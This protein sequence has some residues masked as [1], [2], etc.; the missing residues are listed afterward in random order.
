MTDQPLTDIDEYLDALPVQPLSPPRPNA[1][2][3]YQVSRWPLLKPYNGFSG[4]ER[5]R[6]GQLAVWL[7]AAG[8]VA[9]PAQCDVCARRE[10]LQLHNETYYHVGRTPALCR[11]CHRAIHLRHWHWDAW[12]RIVDEAATSGE[13]WFALTPRY[14]LNLAE[15]LRS[16]WGWAVVD[17][18]AS[19]ITPLSKSVAALL[20]NNMLVHPFVP[21]GKPSDPASGL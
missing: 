11:R 5:R 3:R 18:E 6:G 4:E 12:R 7:L 17:I 19:P 14:G 9:L 2:T 15:H 13:E 16:R 10:P 20:P 8:C 1:P 21:S